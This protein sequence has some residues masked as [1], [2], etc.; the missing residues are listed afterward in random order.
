MFSASNLSNIFFHLLLLAKE[1]GA[2]ETISNFLSATTS[3][4][5]DAGYSGLWTTKELAVRHSA[6]PPA[7]VP[8]TGYTG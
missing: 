7:L 2:G 8:L 5:W 1:K 3:S 4:R 6:K